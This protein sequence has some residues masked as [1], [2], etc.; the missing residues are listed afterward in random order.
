[1]ASTETMTIQAV[2][3]ENIRLGR[4]EAKIHHDKIDAALDAATLQ[5]AEDH[6]SIQAAIDALGT[7]TGMTDAEIKALYSD[8]VV[9]IYVDTYEDFEKNPGK[10]IKILSAEDA[11]SDTFVGYSATY[12][13]AVITLAK[14]GE[15][16][17]TFEVSDEAKKASGKISG[18]NV[19]VEYYPV[20]LTHDFT[21]N[22]DKLLTILQADGTLGSTFAGYAAALSGSTIT[23]T[24]DSETTYTFTIGEE[25]ASA[26]GIVDSKNYKVTFT[27]AT[28][29]EVTE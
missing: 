7:A 5:A 23:L 9:E 21:N 28:I 25:G 8:E 24:K 17:Y 6:A 20:V 12:A 18:E 13:S 10:L 11:F 4:I 27:T 29:T 14:D 3:Q 26:T 16:T 15:T 19:D 22:P 1:M 2:V